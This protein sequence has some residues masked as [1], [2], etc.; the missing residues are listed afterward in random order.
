MNNYAWL[1][2]FV[3]QCMYTIHKIH[4]G[5]LLG[6]CTNGAPG[7]RRTASTLHTS[8]LP[9]G[10]SSVAT[11]FAPPYP[12]PP[13]PAR[14][15]E[16]RPGEDPAGNTWIISFRGNSVPKLP[17]HFALFA[18]NL[19]WKLSSLNKFSI[20]KFHDLGNILPW[21]FRLYWTIQICPHQRD[22]TWKKH[23]SFPSSYNP[24]GNARTGHHLLP[25][26]RTLLPDPVATPGPSWKFVPSDP[27]LF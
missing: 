26:I 22:M 15:G 5:G 7:W 16:K 25:R 4:M 27:I 14:S 10:L 3:P 20:D 13:Y 2:I 23:R 17:I 1:Y 24:A 6:W 11:C 9:L 8:L 19:P 18:R 12:S 21:P